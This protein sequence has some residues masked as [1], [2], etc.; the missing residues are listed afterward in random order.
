M[1]HLTAILGGALVTMA[2]CT[3][4]ETAETANDNLQERSIR[5]EVLVEAPPEQVF[6]LF[7]TADGVR[8]FFAP[9]ANIGV[10]PG[11]PY[12]IILNPVADPDG[13]KLGTKG[14]R[15]RALE[16][17]RLI[18]FEWT[19]PSFGDVF[20]TQPFPTAVEVRVEPGTFPDTTLVHFVH[21]GFP[22]AP[23]WNRVF[24]LYRDRN[25]PLVLNRL[26]VLCRDGVSPEWSKARG[27]FVADILLKARTIPAS[28]DTVWRSWATEEGLRGFLPAEVRMEPAPGGPFE[29]YWVPDAPE[30]QR[31][32]EG[33]TVV[34]IDPPR[35][36]TFTWNAPPSFPEVRKQHTN[37]VVQLEPIDDSSTRLRLLSIGWGVSEEWKSSYAY[38]DQ[39]WDKVLDWVEESLAGGGADAVTQIRSPS[40]EPPG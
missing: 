16:P 28:R 25:W 35:S 5:Y 13:S 4:T 37:V 23:E 2:A 20:N 29:I 15:I 32:S 40:A 34:H 39:A 9:Q 14:C 18:S 36:I 27:E 26:L 3:P 19:F 11:D 30:G 33:C 10:E 38:F 31:G 7:S 24:T 1:R 8:S 22:S 21:R 12:E 17:D 6:H